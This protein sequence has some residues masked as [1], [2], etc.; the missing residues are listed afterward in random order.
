MS[1]SRW[2]KKC[3]L[4]PN[5]GLFEGG[6]FIL[7]P[8]MYQ[9]EFSKCLFN[10]NKFYPSLLSLLYISL[11]KQMPRISLKNICVNIF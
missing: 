9:E 3:M 5:S 7:A 2:L 10:L 11:T 4:L 8:I 6:A 1:F